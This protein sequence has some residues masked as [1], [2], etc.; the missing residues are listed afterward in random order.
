[1]GLPLELRQEIYS[2]AVANSD[3]HAFD[4]KLNEAA[5]VT[6]S[7]KWHAPPQASTVDFM[8]LCRAHPMIAREALPVFYATAVPRVVCTR[9][10]LKPLSSQRRMTYQSVPR[11]ASSSARVVDRA[12]AEPLHRAPTPC[13][14]PCR[15]S[16]TSASTS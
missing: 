1:M 7:T 3:W 12:S 10:S 8:A 14:K 6:I 11:I 13:S 9:S 4:W 15:A 5:N 16:G 2:F